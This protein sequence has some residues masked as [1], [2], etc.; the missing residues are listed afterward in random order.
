LVWCSKIITNAKES[1][2]QPSPS[3]RGQ[4]E[5]NIHVYIV[6]QLPTPSF[7]EGAGGGE[8]SIPTSE[9]L[10]FC[11]SSLHADNIKT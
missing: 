9:F 10:H 8:I 3:R 5:V 1:Y 6:M 2:Y 11:I 4:G 7:Q